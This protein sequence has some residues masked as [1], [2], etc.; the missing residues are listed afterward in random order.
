MLGS[1]DRMRYNFMTCGRIVLIAKTYACN[2]IS[3]ARFVDCGAG[4]LNEYFIVI[5]QGRFVG[6]DI[7][8]FPGEREK[9]IAFGIMMM[10][11]G[12]FVKFGMSGHVRYPFLERSAFDNQDNRKEGH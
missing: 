5:E 8:R 3:G 12:R 11:I 7:G 10:V 4:T 1:I 6:N 9:Y 2:N